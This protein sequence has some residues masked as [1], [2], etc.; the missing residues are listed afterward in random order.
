ME[1]EAVDRLVKLFHTVYYLIQAAR[2]LSDLVGLCSLQERNG[3]MIGNSYRNDKPAA[4]FAHF[5][6]EVGK[7]DLARKLRQ[8]EFFSV[9]NDS[10]T[11]VSVADEELIYVRYLEDGR[12]VTRFLSLQAMAKSDALG[13]LADIDKAFLDE[14]GMQRDEWREKVVVLQCWKV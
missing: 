7:G 3:V 11:D 6:A 13:I 4:T 1:R 5:I 14:L 12:P 8:V 2:P 9:L 10:S